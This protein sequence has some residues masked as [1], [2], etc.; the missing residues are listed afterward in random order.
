MKTINRDNYGNY[1]LDYIEGKLDRNLHEELQAFLILNP[2]LKEELESF[3]EI[4]LTPDDHFFSNKNSL[5]KNSEL[6]ITSSTID[7]ICIAYYENDLNLD[8]KNDLVKFI[9]INS[10]EKKLFKLF[11]KTYL[12]PDKTIQFDKKNSLKRIRIQIPAYYRIGLAAAAIAAIIL[13]INLFITKP[14]EQNVAVVSK[15]LQQIHTVPENNIREEKPPSII[16]IENKKKVQAINHQEQNDKVTIEHKNKFIKNDFNINPISSKEAKIESFTE[17]AIAEKLKIPAKNTKE[18]Y[19]T[20]KE[21]AVEKIKTN[22]LKLKK[23][24]EKNSGISFWDFMEAGINGIE[25][26][27]NVDIDMKRDNEEGKIKALALNTK[28]FEISKS[29]N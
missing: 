2:D 21:Y 9:E 28:K 15:N 8:E 3:D 14:I 25:N 29:F 26:I 17:I 11:E 22:V 12:K 4:K 7:D 6:I 20:V 23:P 10:A 1:F 27:S 19:P 5:K 16:A 13:A 24:I 18:Y